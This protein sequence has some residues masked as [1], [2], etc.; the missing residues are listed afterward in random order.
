MNIKKYKDFFLLAGK[1][2]LIL[3]GYDIVQIIFARGKIDPGEIDGTAFIFAVYSLFCLFYAYEEYKTNRNDFIKMLRK[4]PLVFFVLYTVW[5]GISCLWSDNFP[6]T[7]YRAVECFSIMLLMVA[8]TV[9]LIKYRNIEIVVKWSIL[10][11]FFT[12]LLKTL[13][14]IVSFGV[15]GFYSPGS[16]F[17]YSAQFI[18]PIFFFF[19][20]LYSKNKFIKFYMISVCIMAMS[21]VGYIAMA[22]GAI[23]LFWGDKRSKRIA[24]IIFGSVILYSAFW[25]IEDLLSHTIFIEHNAFEEGDD[26]G[27]SFVWEMGWEYFKD[28]PI[29]GHGFFVAENTLARIGHMQTVVGMHNGFMSALVGEGIIGEVFFVLFF[30][31][32]SF[33]SISKRM[34]LRYKSAL[35][36]SFIAVF[37]E[38]YANPGLGFRIFNAWMPSMY[39]CVLICTFYCFGDT[40]KYNE[41]KKLKKTIDSI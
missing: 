29:F 13:Q 36:A 38:T 18:C 8:V 32:M 21:T 17:W 12:A 5:G 19:T 22:A 4:S 33:V 25:G 2:G 39:A 16:L 30:I 26:S 28:S 35:L 15:E 7:A 3:L 40:L 9:K 31:G 24:Y 10:Y 37:F 23:A 20:F 27:R 1:P 11:I 34:P 6:L 14:G 41:N